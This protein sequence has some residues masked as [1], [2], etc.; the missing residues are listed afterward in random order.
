MGVKVRERKPGEWWI[1]IDHKGRRKAVKVGAKAA[2]KASAIEIEKKITTGKL[3]LNRGDLTPVTFE[4]YAEKWM[5]QHVQANCKPGTADTNRKALDNHLL[6]SFGPVLL[7]DINREAL[8][9]Y[10]ATKKADGYSLSIHPV[11]YVLHLGTN[12]DGGR[13]RSSPGK[14]LRGSKEAR[15]GR[16]VKRPIDAMT[17]EETRAFL[18]AAREHTPRFY[19]LF[20]TGLRTGMRIGELVALEWGDIDWRG[21]FIVVQRNF[22]QGTLGTPKNGKTR[23]V[24]MSDQLIAEL[25][26]HK[27]RMAAE[28]LK[29]GRSLPEFL[30]STVEGRRLWPHVARRILDALTRKA[31]IR[32]LNP[33]IFRHTF[34]TRPPRRISRS[35][36][37]SSSS[38]TH[39]SV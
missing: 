35:P 14:S 7:A 1:F 12:G 19:P 32:K 10:C 23:R 5:E 27:R 21:K 8:R 9:A 18:A 3:D 30:F 37:S 6:P 34:A 22:W 15:Q 25:T 36:T 29:E 16:K 33:H 11:A 20:L 31:G 28:S 26:D 17:H 24:D 2:A 38:G 4:K 13:G 39:R